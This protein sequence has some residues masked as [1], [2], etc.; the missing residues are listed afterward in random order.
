MSASLRNHDG[1]VDTEVV[2]PIH[3]HEMAEILNGLHVEHESEDVDGKDVACG[4]KANK[5]GCACS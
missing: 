4:G 1:D 5:E 2:F 3:G